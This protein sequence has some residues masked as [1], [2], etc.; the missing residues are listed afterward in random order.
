[1]FKGQEGRYADSSS[2]MLP[3]GGGVF[4][5]PHAWSRGSSGYS[6]AHLPSLRDPATRGH[7]KQHIFSK[8]A[9]LYRECFQNH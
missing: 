8:L 2:I 6:A 9:A 7:K 4:S 1:M 3:S 5:L